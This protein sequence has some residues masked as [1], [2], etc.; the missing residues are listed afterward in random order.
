MD[1]L[2]LERMVP[3][4]LCGQKSL[5]IHLFVTWIRDEKVLRKTT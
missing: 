5:V 4:K 1:G 3:M 2:T